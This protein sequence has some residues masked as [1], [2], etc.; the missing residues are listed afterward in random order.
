MLVSDMYDLIEESLINLA[1][2]NQIDEVNTSFYSFNFCLDTLLRIDAFAAIKMLKANIDFLEGT[3]DLVQ[4][5][6][7]LN[8]TKMELMRAYTLVPDGPMIH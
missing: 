6:T 8:I 3:I 5:Q 7:Q 2:D 1:D 4:Y